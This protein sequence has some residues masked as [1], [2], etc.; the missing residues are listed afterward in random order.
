LLGWL[1]CSV[2]PFLAEWPHHSA[3][4][5]SSRQDRNDHFPGARLAEETS[6]FIRSAPGRHDIIHKQNAFSG[7][8]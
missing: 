2:L 7:E 1:S 8:L 5:L 6:G 4:A 3:R